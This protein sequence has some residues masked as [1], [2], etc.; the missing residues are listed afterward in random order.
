MTTL[1]AVPAALV[2]RIHTALSVLAFSTALFLGWFAG[3]WEQLCENSVAK[4][5]VEWF[6]SVSATIGDHVA[7]RA[8][9]QI[10]I[11]LTATPRFVLLGLQWIAH[12][13]PPST[14]VRSSSAP[15][16]AAAAPSA[17]TS[18][19]QGNLRS[20]AKT[21]KDDDDASHPLTGED[22]G[23]ARPASSRT[24]LVDAEI[25]FGVART[26]C[27]G[28]WMYI[29]SRDQHDL[30]DLFMIIYLVLNLPWMYLS[31][32]HSTNERASKWRKITFGGFL[33]SIPP[34]VY[35]FI[36]HSVK[37][38]PGSY[39]QYAFFEWSLVVWD[40]AFDAATLFELGHLQVRIIDT[41][42]SLANGAGEKFAQ[43]IYVAP[44]PGGSVSR[45]EEDWTAL[46]SP[47]SRLPYRD[48][49]AWLSD[50]WF[51]AAFW[52]VFTSVSVQLFYWSVWKLALSGSELAIF[53][54]LA[55]F[56]L[57]RPW[58]RAYA[59]SKE[60]LF[61]HR[62]L[63][64]VVGLGT[65]ALPSVGA[66]YLCVLIG[67]WGGW[68][69]LTAD[70]YRLRGS[71]EMLAQGKILISGLIVTLLAKYNAYSNNPFWPLMDAASGGW[72]KTGLVISA[73]ALAEYYYR[74]NNLFPAPP[75]GA[76]LK[77]KP[78]NLAFSR[79]QRFLI[80]IGFGASVHLIQTFVTDS[81]TI[82]AWSWTG[83]PLTGPTLHPWSGLVIL[84]VIAGLLTEYTPSNANVTT[85]SVTTLASFLALDKIP[86]WAGFLAGLALVFNI[87]VTF[88]SLLRAASAMP[89][90]V[91]GRAMI[92][93]C[94]VDVAS[95]FTVAYAFVPFGWI[96]RERTDLVT[97]LIVVALGAGI[98]GAATLKLPDESRL[99]TRSKNRIHGINHLTR[100][101]AAVF[102]V[103]TIVTSFTHYRAVPTKT[104]Q[105]KP[106]FPNHKL[107]SGGIFTVHFGIDEPG[108]DSQR[109][110][111]Q[112]IDEMQVDVLGMLETDLHRFV[113]GNRD[114][115]R[116][117]AEELDY[118]VDIGPGP[119]KHTWG[120]ALLSK[121]P[122]LNST[123][124]L[125]PSPGG[126]LAPAIHATLDI[127]GQHINVIV[128]HNG[129]EEDPLDRELQTTELAR[130]LHETG[131]TPT[132]FL[133]YLVTHLHDPPP[134]PY[135]ILFN[136]HTGLI[137]IETLDRWRWCEYIGFRNLWRI[138]FARLE[139]S[140]VTDTELQVGKF[141]LPLPGQTVKYEDESQ[142]EWH[143]AETDI[144]EVWRMP[145]MFRDPGI[146]GH[147][148]R[149]WDGPLYYL[150]PVHSRLRE[151][152][153]GNDTSWPP[154]AQ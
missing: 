146:R 88:P 103:V 51:A 151:Y 36:Q 148:Y 74:P 19:Y 85:V 134:S 94:I 150:P 131:D 33:A 67:M 22:A 69:A 16:A 121:F 50:V 90:A 93:N 53:I 7:P 120:A 34:L 137:D 124:H 8:P 59:T 125:L 37:H 32:V 21:H 39:T 149:I 147:M 118:Y 54:N 57:G 135:G 12:R 13:Y 96:L 97:G 68:I 143:I 105:P 65:Y 141:L 40:V 11:A 24:G 27:C 113:Y 111:A 83:W 108:R 3:L 42:S 116:Y 5:P 2:P 130:L 117:I 129:Q 26:F 75:V 10:L 144:P 140:D 78:L 63:L 153:W 99:Q 82:I 119:N 29:T 133:G 89:P 38:V 114:L 110:I 86:D 154:V 55:P 107:F 25:M 91:T 60:G 61:F 92:F 98:A 23:P 100:L 44:V 30:H 106:Y 62:S 52:T 79:S 15:A 71:P 126:E 72:N 136:N 87:V 49:L 77:D 47:P 17:S 46:P 152:G 18:T 31:T 145:T 81:G 41:T 66:R 138:A 35:L 139:H 112:L 84:V 123:H 73:L 1:V 58:F 132:V 76:T 101:A 64:Y 95:V 109:R 56:A 122:I 9:F 45:S 48:G 43:G 80:A 128:S 115:T 104:R 102:A 127:H 28:G 6:P 14:S 70:S 4:W 20:R 142:L